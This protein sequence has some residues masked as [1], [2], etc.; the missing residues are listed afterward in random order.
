MLADPEM[1]TAPYVDLLSNKMMIPLHRDKAESFI[2][3]GNPVG[4]LETWDNI[5]TCAED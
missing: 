5:V 2:Q 4:M 1:N 3:N